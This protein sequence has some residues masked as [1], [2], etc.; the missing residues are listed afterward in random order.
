LCGED[1]VAPLAIIPNNDAQCN[2]IPKLSFDEVKSIFKQKTSQTLRASLIV[3]C[4][5]FL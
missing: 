2:V 4:V 5:T 1:L 3:F